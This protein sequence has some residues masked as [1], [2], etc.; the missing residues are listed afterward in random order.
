MKGT[1]TA[2][3]V[4]AAQNADRPAAPGDLGRRSANAAPATPSRSSNLGNGTPRP[5][6]GI[7]LSRTTN[8][9]FQ[10]QIAPSESRVA[11]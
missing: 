2:R 11:T 6:A 10:Y 8:V 1:R 7:Q 3:A 9:Q 4:D 5:S